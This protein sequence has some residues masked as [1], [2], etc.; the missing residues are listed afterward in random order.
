MPP[1]SLS[2]SWNSGRH[3]DGAEMLKEIRDL[4]FEYA[5]LGHGIRYSLWP[6]VLQALQ[7]RVVKLSSLHNFCPVPT[8]ILRPSPNC[9]QF[10]DPRPNLRKAA[11]KAT[12]ETVRQAAQLKAPAVV[13]H[14]GTAGPSGLSDKLEAWYEKNKLFSRQYVAAKVNAVRYRREVFSTYQSRLQECLEPVIALAVQ[15]GIKLG[16]EIREIFEEFPHEG[17][18][19]QLLADYP[20]RTVGYWHDFGHSAR[21]DFLGWHTHAETLMRRRNRLL[22]CHIH[23]CRPPAHDHLPLGHGEIDFPSLVPL[24]NPN[25]ITVLELSPRCTREQVIASQKLWNSYA[26]IPV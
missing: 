12:L 23:D 15:E 2:T 7:E 25:T 22:G 8:G 1:L 26:G 20:P 11:I 10:T 13:L 24:L 6:G 16:F 3:Q 5:E 14:L 4:G 19:E 21:K 18:M 17:E 9:Y